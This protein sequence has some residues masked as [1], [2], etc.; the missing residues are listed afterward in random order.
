MPI[1]E[2][3]CE[4][5]GH[6]HEAFQK[7]SD[8]LLKECPNCHKPSL[9]KLVSAAGFRLKG[10]GWYETDFKGGDKKKN[11]AQSEFSESAGSSQDSIG[12]ET[13]P[14]KPND[15]TQSG[16]SGSGSGSGSSSGTA[17]GSSDSK[18]GGSSETKSGTTSEKTSGTTSG[19]AS[20]KKEGVGNN[21]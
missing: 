6:Q 11:L 1:Y 2:Y 5:C 7:I 3:A 9:I 15:K 20:G 14:P 17:S 4:A 21:L 8:P 13:G 10:S 18:S 12:P 16:E 19:T